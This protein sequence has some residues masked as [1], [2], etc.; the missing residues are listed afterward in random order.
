MIVTK[1]T[2]KN[3][4]KLTVSLENGV[5]FVLYKGDFRNYHIAENENLPE[6]EFEEIMGELLPKR[7]LDR[8]YKLLMSKDYTEKQIREKLNADGYPENIIENTVTKLKEQ[9]YLNDSRYTENFIFWKAKSKSKRRL[10]TDLRA[11]GIGSGDAEEIYN[12]LLARNDIDSEEDVAKEFLQKKG[13]DAKNA[14]F[15]EKEKMK[16]TLL[17]KGYSFDTVFHL[18]GRGEW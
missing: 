14:T 13:F 2:E 4:K 9:K 15:E 1:I 18:L 3:K 16:Q 11:K 12:K 8:S 6:K 5:A 17:R 10:M 7:A